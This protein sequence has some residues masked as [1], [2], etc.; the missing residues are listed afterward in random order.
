MHQ[1][2]E[3][4]CME[5]ETVFV[6]FEKAGH[7]I[8]YLG[9]I[10]F[11][12]SIIINLLVYLHVYHIQ[13]HLWSNY[14]EKTGPRPTFFEE[15]MFLL[16][17]ISKEIGEIFFAAW[18]SALACVYPSV[19]FILQTFN[20]ALWMLNLKYTF[21]T[22]MPVSCIWMVI[23]GAIEATPFTNFT[24]LA[25][26]KTNLYSDLMLKIKER[27]M[28]VNMLIT[29]SYIGKFF[30]LCLSMGWFEYYDP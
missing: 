3:N 24:F 14:F 20:A 23:T 29:A 22:N 25:I 13:F 16:F 4:N 2:V 27:E 1:E 9:W 5:P 26:A 10:S 8:I 15:H 28:V 7:L 12:G 6:T 11:L 19:P 17:H 18:I 30:A 21:I